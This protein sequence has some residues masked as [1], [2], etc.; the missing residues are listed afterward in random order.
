M[1]AQGRCEGGG[2][3]ARVE[4]ESELIIPRPVRRNPVH[5]E[6]AADRDGEAQFLAQLADRGMIGR[7]VGLRH[8]SG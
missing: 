2:E 7:L 1:W 3:G 5:D 4:D 6:Q 8:A